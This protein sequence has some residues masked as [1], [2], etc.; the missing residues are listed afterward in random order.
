MDHSPGVAA[1]PREAGERP[2]PTARARLRALLTGRNL[3]RLAVLVALAVALALLGSPHLLQPSDRYAIGD[4]ATRALRAPYD[5][6]IVDEEATRQQREAA[7]ARAPI[8]AT[9][10]TAV[11]AS[12]RARFSSAWAPANEPLAELVSSEAPLPAPN[13]T[14]TARARAARR[15]E[16]ARRRQRAD[17]ARRALDE[18]FD[19]VEQTLGEPIP[20]EVRRAV[21][22]PGDLATLLAGFDRL[23]GEAYR[24][25]L[26]SSLEPFAALSAETAQAAP[27]PPVAL[28]DAASRRETRLEDPERV[29]DL[30]AA[31]AAV[32]ARAPELA[33]EVPDDVRAWLANM[34]ARSL[35]PD[36]VADE[37]ATRARRDAAADAV[38]P[39]SISFRRNQLV[40]GEG[41][42][43]TRQAL[44]VL[45]AIRQQRMDRGSWLRATGRAGVILA[46]FLLAFIVVDHDRTRF[47]IDSYDFAYGLTSL[48]ATVA[49][50]R[51]WLEMV[52]GL[53]E[54]YPGLP[55]SALVLAF[56]AAATVMHARVV[57]PYASAV[58]YLAV[59]AICMGLLWQLDLLL[60]VFLLISGLVAGHL[61]ANCSRRQCVL[62]AGLLAG[63]LM[64]PVA[65]CL[66]LL[67]GE[68]SG[69]SVAWMVVG[70]MVGCAASGLSLLAIGPLF[71]WM[72]GHMTRIRLVELMNYHHPLLRRVTEAT[73]GTFQHSVTVALLVDAAAQAVGA[74]ALLGRVG[75]LYHDAGKT[76][77]PELFVENQHERNP[78]DD[79]PPHESARRI[80]A[81][82]EAG[83]RLVREF[84]LGER[85]ADFVREHHGT[86][87]VRYFM[88]RAAAQGPVDAA[89]FQ[90][91][92]PRPGSAETGILMLADQVE[93]T[94]RAMDAPTPEGLRAMVQQTI[95][96][97]LAEGQL[98]EC[99]L[100]VQ[101]LASVREAFVQVLMGAHHRRIKYPGQPATFDRPAPGPVPAARRG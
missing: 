3:W 87:L 56:P 36:T 39:V 38:L 64:A 85:I 81:H 91:P 24:V 66:A 15:D 63:L 88:A 7:A 12:L 78:H 8:V 61:A 52:S 80:I 6:S 28:V 46:L 95:D 93:A 58:T 99:P 68:A 65:A 84:G 86:S 37:A 83:V 11:Q 79:L 97:T 2:R 72:F 21:S 42:P 55:E 77:Q 23:V 40:V 20:A 27:K 19:A 22:T 4:F 67:T 50:F 1:D 9:V 10:D 57:L 94:A 17:A 47:A 54:R 48:T 70:A 44:L 53:A 32:V 76:E 18:A 5:L 49:A 16:E 74:D 71:E 75:A 101:Q 69:A 51:L 90:Y 26:V 62:Q 98:D 82:V 89:A 96:R 60:V 41:Q 33:P 29:R 13:G 59:Q 25:P 43:L 100:T 14:L 73:P 92:G 31:R 45:E 34:A 30:D 35:R